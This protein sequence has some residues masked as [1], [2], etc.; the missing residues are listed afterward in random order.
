MKP[1]HLLLR[2][3][4]ATKYLG[5]ITSVDPTGRALSVEISPPDLPLDPHGHPLPRRHLICRA[6]A[7]LRSPASPDPLLDLADYLQSLTLILTAA[8]AS[9]ILKSLPS[10]SQSLD[11]FRFCSAL[12]GF[13]HDCFTY[14]RILSILSKSGAQI[15][16]IMKV[17]EE[18]ERDGTRGSISTVNILIGIV[19]AG[20][21]EKCLELARKWGL[22]FNGYTYKCLLQAYLRSRDV[23]RASRVYE[24]MRRK[25]HKLD[26]FAY[27]MLLDALAKANKVWIVEFFYLQ[28]ERSDFAIELLSKCS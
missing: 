16:S 19:G 23:E 12:P 9:E 7:I 26:I 18:M 15:E 20:E 5:R 21:I 22:R 11:F 27:N 13:K 6:T 2:R 3:T 17:V 14:N 8:E 4:F 24:E 10:P 25:G 28:F 1:H